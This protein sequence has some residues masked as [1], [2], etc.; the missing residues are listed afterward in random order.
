MLRVSS[1][2]AALLTRQRA[3]RVRLGNLGSRMARF[4]RRDNLV[5][6]RARYTRRDNPGSRARRASR[7]D[8]SARRDNLTA[9]FA[10]KDNPG[11]PD[12]QDSRTAQLTLKGSR[13]NPMPGLT[14]KD[15]R[16]LQN[17][18]SRSVRSPRKRRASTRNNSARAILSL[19]QRPSQ[20][21]AAVVSRAVII[22]RLHHRQI[23]EAHGRPAVEYFNGRFLI[24]AGLGEEDVVHVGLRVAVV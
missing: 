23:D 19:G 22:G 10:R 2:R 12:N 4:G 14:R 6:R 24:V 18:R 3:R 15:S 5:S 1:V 17:R 20:Y 11:S 16:V 8:L 9:Q 21:S 13:D 7:M